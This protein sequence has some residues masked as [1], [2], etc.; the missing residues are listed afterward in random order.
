MLAEV[1][2]GEEAPAPAAPKKG[3]GRPPGSP[4][5]EKNSIRIAIRHS[6]TV[7]MGDRNFAK[8][9]VEVEMTDAKSKEDLAKELGEFARAEVDRQLG[10]YAAA[11]DEAKAS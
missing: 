3:P 8:V 5:K 4:N 11:M 9:E 1:N 10:E 6:L 2:G 7:N